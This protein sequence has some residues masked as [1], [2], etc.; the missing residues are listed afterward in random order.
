MKHIKLL[1]SISLLLVFGSKI[2]SQVIKENAKFLYSHFIESNGSTQLFV[3]QMYYLDSY[4]FF[5]DNILEKDKKV[6]YIRNYDTIL[7]YD[8][9]LN[10]GDTF[11]FKRIYDRK[12]TMIV[13]T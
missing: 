2:H 9:S 8:Y 6:F 10:I 13:D 4:Y 1:F 11:Y 7:Y 12:D 3:N 5:E